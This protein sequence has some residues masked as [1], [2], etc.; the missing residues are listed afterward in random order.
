MGEK[1]KITYDNKTGIYTITADREDF[2]ILQLTDIH[3]GGTI[4]TA[5]RDRKAIYACDKL[6]RYTKPDLVVV[7]GDLTYP[8]RGLKYS[9]N[10]TKLVRRFASFMW[11]TGVPWAFTYGNH[12]T[13]KGAILS[14]E[15]LHQ[16]LALLAGRGGWGR[17]EKGLLYP[18]EKPEIYGRMN[19]LIEVRNP[20][21]KLRQALFLIDSN[22]YT[23]E[24]TRE[25]DYIHDDQVDWYRNEVLRLN[26]EE[27]RTVSSLIFTHIPLQQ[28]KTAFDLYKEGSDEVKYFFGFNE[29]K[30]V[31]K[32]C[33]SPNP[34]ILFDTAKDL[35]STKGIFCGH[36]H[37]NNMSLEYEGIRLTYGMSIDYVVMHRIARKTRQRGATLIRCNQ[38]GSMSIEQIPLTSIPED[39]PEFSII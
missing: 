19:Q 21:G 4:F 1:R 3:L 12:D 27:G 30:K 2:R 8:M 32:I 20:D 5:R 34:S 36:D 33:C 16:M 35:G 9:Y 7:T 25:Y 11:H 18:K 22:A 13:E 39:F 31:G 37:Y 15:G 14:P 6:I 10:T 23:S 24:K 29:E 26:A 38:G 17:H 28:Y